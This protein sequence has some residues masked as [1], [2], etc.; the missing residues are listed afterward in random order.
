MGGTPSA[1]WEDGSGNVISGSGVSLSGSLLSCMNE[2][3]GVEIMNA[4]SPETA[5][6]DMSTPEE[7]DGH[8]EPCMYACKDTDWCNSWVYRKDQNR[9]YGKDGG[10]P[11]SDGGWAFFTFREG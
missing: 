11:G 2:A 1:W 9:C 4:D 8:W 6:A 5:H 10:L 7:L 3:G